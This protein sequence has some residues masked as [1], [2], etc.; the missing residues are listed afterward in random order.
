MPTSTTPISSAAPPSTVRKVRIAYFVTH[1]IQYQAPL[2]RCISNQ[3]NIDLTVFFFSDFSTRA[4]VDVGFGVAVQWDIPLLEGYRHEFLPTIRDRGRIGF[5][6]PICHGIW[7]A[8]QNGRFDIVWL[9]GYHTL[10][11]LQVLL[12]ARALGLP[13]LLR[14]DSTLTDR[15]RN[16]LKLLTKKAFFAGLR[17]AVAGLL[18]V[19]QANAEY[20]TQH[21]PGKPQFL[22]PYAVDNEYFQA[23]T[24]AASVRHEE[25]RASLGLTPQRP[26]VLFASKLQTRK[27]CID[28]VEAYFKLYE[29]SPENRKP[30]LVIVGDGEEWNA[31]RTRI[32][33]KLEND[34][35]MT[36]FRNQSELPSFFDLCDVF[37]LPSVWEP[38][39]L[40]VNEVMNAAR[41]VIVSDEVGCHRDLVK[42]RVTGMVFKAGNVDEL[43]QALEYILKTPERTHE[44]GQRA[45]EHIQNFSYKQDITALMRSISYLTQESQLT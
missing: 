7:K 14:T 40:I 29:R 43:A 36:G 3:T 34:I 32:G 18:P 13:L 24:K 27:R 16:Q 17:P 37:V 35:L 33:N 6:E 39:G 20:W 10:N 8:L 11:H 31:I 5:A 15:P 45:L 38:F 22:M 12:A 26:V 25:F 19:G 42:H 44:M 1:P 4:Y 28:L 30:Y 23:K 21:L 41:P 2:L 9:H